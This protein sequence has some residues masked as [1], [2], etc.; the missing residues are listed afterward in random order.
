MIIIVDLD[1]TLSDSSHREHLA[2]AKEWDAFH[3]LLGEDK[4]HQEV[5]MLVR[6][7][8]FSHQVILLTG[9]NE[10]FKLLTLEWLEVQGLSGFVDDLLMRPNGN[11]E[12]DHELKPK[13]LD[14][15]LEANGHSHNDIW[16]ILEDRDKV[17]E[18]WRNLGHNCWQVR[19][20]GY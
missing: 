3:S 4:V 17:V 9:R 6:E 1:G 20:G 13:L 15:W 14:S 5:A 16:F 7:L 2:R 11:W 8:S 18:A 12:P 19:P 10:E